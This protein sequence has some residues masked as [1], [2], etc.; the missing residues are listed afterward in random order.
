MWEGCPLP[1]DRGVW[2]PLPRILLLALKMV[3]FGAFWIVILHL[4]CLITA[5]INI[6]SV[7]VTD[8]ETVLRHKKD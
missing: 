3:S 5:Y 2:G 7:C 1:T 4:N 8:S 6:M